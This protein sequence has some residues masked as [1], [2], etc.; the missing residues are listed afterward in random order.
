MKDGQ[1][2]VV[3]RFEVRLTVVIFMAIWFG[4]V[5]I[6]LRPPPGRSLPAPHSWWLVVSR[7]LGSASYLL[8]T[9]GQFLIDFLRDAIIARE[10]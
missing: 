10:A 5:L 2:R 7:S 6:A 1:T 9:S 8:E 3:C 4:G